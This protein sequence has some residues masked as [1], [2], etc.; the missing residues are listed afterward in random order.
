MVTALF[1][2]AHKE[3]FTPVEPYATSPGTRIPT[4]EP[5]TRRS[6]SPPSMIEIPT[7]GETRRA[8][9][10]RRGALSLAADKICSFAS[11]S[12]G[13]DAEIACRVDPHPLGVVHGEDQCPWA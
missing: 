11:G 2:P 6:L 4:S 10:W 1:A 7:S 9:A 8:V 5:G 3:V 12:I 13:A